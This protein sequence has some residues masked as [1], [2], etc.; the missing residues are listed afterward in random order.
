[1]IRYLSIALFLLFLRKL[2]TKSGRNPLVNGRECI[3]KE[4]TEIA[5][6]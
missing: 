4:R 1:M 6:L 5:K 3:N 2:T